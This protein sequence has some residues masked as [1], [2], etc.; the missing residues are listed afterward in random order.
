MDSSV[1]Q[2]DEIWFLRV[3]RHISNAVYDTLVKEIYKGWEDEEYVVS[4]Y[5]IISRRKQ[6]A[7]NWKKEVNL[8]VYPCTDA[9]ELIVKF[10]TFFFLSMC[11]KFDRWPYCKGGMRMRPH[12][13]SVTI[14]FYIFHLTRIQTY[15]DFC[16]VQIIRAVSDSLTVVMAVS[17]W[18]HLCF[19]IL[20]AFCILIFLKRVKQ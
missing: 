20:K 1:S 4:S 10:R 14:T 13:M 5:L 8:R 17:T 12:I 6:D 16:Y 3:C 18:V 15:S 7:G 9:G 19:G 11:L 2:E